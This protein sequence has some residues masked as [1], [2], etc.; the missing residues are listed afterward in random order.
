MLCKKICSQTEYLL[1]AKH[2]LKYK[3]LQDEWNIVPACKNTV[4]CALKEGQNWKGGV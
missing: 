1:H 2:G 4:S 3:N